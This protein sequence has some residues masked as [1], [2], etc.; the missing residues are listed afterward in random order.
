MSE[1]DDIVKYLDALFVK[2]KSL[3]GIDALVTAGPTQE[4]I[5]PVRYISNKSSSLQ[6]I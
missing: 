5:D 6:V 4:P 1:P 2:T 3:D